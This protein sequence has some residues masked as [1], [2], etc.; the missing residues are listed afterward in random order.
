MK[1]LTRTDL[2]T[3]EAYASERSAFRAK[4]I[5]H[6]KHRQVPL[7]EHINLLF[8]DRLTIQYQV[9]EMLRIERI[10][11]PAAIQDELDTYNALIPT[12]HNL[13]ATMLIEFPDEAQRRVEL[14]RLGGI[15]H[16]VYGEVE[17]LGRAFAIA[18][19]D[20]DRSNSEKTSAVHFLRFEFGAEQIA[21]LRAGAEFGFGID[22]ERLRVGYT[23]KRDS[24]AALLADFS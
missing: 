10:F 21:A 13:K 20:M 6:K 2:L 4:V 19:E 23:V 8:E 22:D 11:E 15:E 12:G 18:D 17:G 7:G 9:Q 5:A 1:A 3:L 24:R 14:A 16:K